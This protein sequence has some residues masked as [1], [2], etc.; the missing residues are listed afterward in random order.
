M[1]AELR[2]SYAR[3]LMRHPYVA[4]DGDD[5][6]FSLGVGI[7]GVPS[8]ASMPGPGDSS[9]IL[10]SIW[11]LA[12]NGDGLGGPGRASREGLAFLMPGSSVGRELHDEELI[13]TPARCLLRLYSSH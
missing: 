10:V 7:S 13:L 9:N 11:V 3:I 1:H 2:E 4:D 8:D 5:R 6:Q 12:W